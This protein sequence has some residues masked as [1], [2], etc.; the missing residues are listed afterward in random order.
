MTDNGINRE[1]LAADMLKWARLKRQLD[2]VEQ[3]ISDTVLQLGETVVVGYTRATYYNPRKSYNYEAG[4]RDAGVQVG[5]VIKH[6]T[7]KT[8]T[9]VDWKAICSEIG[10]NAPYTESPARVALK[11]DGDP[12]R[13]PAYDGQPVDDGLAF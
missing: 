4:A 5:M 1:A 7:E 10:A 8:V 9:S 6:T 11:L 12:P 3:A 2:E 13:L